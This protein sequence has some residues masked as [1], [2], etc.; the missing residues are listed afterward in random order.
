MENIDQGIAQVLSRDGTSPQLL[1]YEPMLSGEA[2]PRIL[3]QRSVFIIGRPLVP[4][5]GGFIGEI[6]VAQVDKPSI[7]ADL[8]LL[9]Y[10]Y[11]SL[12]QDTY[13]FA[14][15]N[16]VQASLA[17]SQIDHR[18]MGNRFYQDGNYLKAI[19]SYTRFASNYPNDHEAYFLRGN[20]H[21]ASGD[22]EAALPDY[23]LAIQLSAE[24]IHDL[25]SHMMYFNRANSKSAIGDLDGALADYA[26][27][28]RRDPSN[29]EASFNRANTLY[30]LGRFC[31][32]VAEYDKMHNHNS[33]NAQFNK[34]NALVILDRFEDA[35][36]CYESAAELGARHHGI[37]QNLWVVS[38]LIEATRGHEYE[39]RMEREGPLLRQM[40]VEV[41]SDSI[42]EFHSS[43][44]PLFIGR[45]GNSGNF[46]GPGLAGGQGFSGEQGILVFVR[47]VS[48]GA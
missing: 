27:A 43:R 44:T 41:E 48:H 21:A 47:K 18:Q 36:K 14:E 11:Q 16:S 22:H 10:S 28:T 39:V 35:A 38:L 23:S 45:V 25:I 31:D 32:A 40:V 37:D 9:D 33:P 8:E 29:T 2:A 42:P 13:G 5:K 6:E 17:R 12:F 1:Y 26:A 19:G 24:S 30:D 46:G 15:A 34:G 3:R 7:L 20:A 4:A